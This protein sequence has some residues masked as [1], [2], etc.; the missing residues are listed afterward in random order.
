MPAV[1]AMDTFFYTS[2]GSYDLTSRCQMLSELGYDGTYLT[3]WS[4][5]AEH[6]IAQ[7]AT[8]PANHKLTVHGVYFMLNIAD[9]DAMQRTLALIAQIPVATTIEL[10]IYVGQPNQHQ[11]DAQYDA[12]ILKYLPQLCHI[13]EQH[14]HQL[15]LYP[16]VHFWLETMADAVRICQQYSHPRLGIA[17]AAYHWYA[18]GQRDLVPTLTQIAPWLKTVNICGSRM[19]PAGQPLPASIELIDTGELD[20]FAV[21][22]QLNRIG[23]TGPIGLQGYGIGGDVYNNLRKSIQTFRDLNNR[24]GLRS[25]WANLRPTDVS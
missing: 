7:L 12:L 21:L 16:H 6:D 24:V 2:L 1:Y 23:Y 10:A 18:I 13:A 17:F 22:C 8:I 15:A 11:R 14:N 20:L 5:H 25:H 19:L 9:D 4:P 3:V